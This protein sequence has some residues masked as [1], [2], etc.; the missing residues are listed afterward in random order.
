MKKAKEVSNH[1]QETILEPLFEKGFFDRL[2]E[3]TKY[4]LSNILK[5]SPVIYDKVI[6]NKDIYLQYFHANYVNLLLQTNVEQKN[7]R[8]SD[9][10]ELKRITMMSILSTI[11]EMYI[12]NEI[13]T[14]LERWKLVKL[15]KRTGMVY[16]IIEED[17]HE[18]KE[19][20]LVKI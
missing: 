11:M 7:I 6:F 10:I 20:S 13:L 3:F 16:T 4:I 2:F 9:P 15:E 17:L 18:L 5:Y 14:L 1:A 19:W 12:E 8:I